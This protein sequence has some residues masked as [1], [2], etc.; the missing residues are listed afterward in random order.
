MTIR[1]GYHYGL[2]PYAGPPPSVTGE[3]TASSFGLFGGAEFD[4]ARDRM[5]FYLWRTISDQ[6]E[7][8]AGGFDA[9]GVGLGG[10]TLDAHHLYDPRTHALFMGD[11]RHVAS[12]P[13]I[14]TYAGTGQPPAFPGQ[15][16]G[17]PATAARLGYANDVEVAPDGS[18]F[19]AEIVSRDS[20]II[21]RIRPDGTAETYVSG[22]GSPRGIALGPDGSLYVTQTNLGTILRIAPDRTITRFAGTG[23]PSGPRGDGGPATSALVPLPIEVA[24]APDGSVYLTDGNAV[25]RVGPDGIITTAVGGNFGASLGDGGP[26]RDAQL[27]FIDGLAVG[28]AGELYIGHSDNGSGA[29]NRIRR[30]DTGGT[31]TT[32]AGEGPDPDIRGDGGP[33]TEAT[34]G[35][36]FGMDVG[37]DGA[38]YFAERVGGGGH[39]RRLGA[40]GVITT[41]AGRTA[42]TFGDNA[43]GDRGPALRALLPSVIGVAVAPDGSVYVGHHGS[44]NFTGYVRRITRPLPIGEGGAGFIPSPD[45]AQAFAFD[46]DGRHVRTVD[47][48]TGGT[49]LSF[50][51]DSAGR[52][53]TITDGDGNVTT[54][55]RAGASVAI[56]APG[57][58]RTELTID[59]EGW[60]SSFEPPDGATQTAAY[61]ANGLMES[62]TD[63]RGGE[64][65][66][67]FNA[68]GLL[69]RDED[70]AGGVTHLSR[71][72]D[73]GRLPR[74]PHH[75]AR[76]HPGLRGP[77]P[78]RRRHRPAVHRH[79]GRR[80][81]GRVTARRHAERDAIPTAWRPTPRAARTR[82]GTSTSPRPPR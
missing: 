39:I 34:I 69:T 56:V 36:P 28:S 19:V 9:R 10:W 4:G 5:D 55:E 30:V 20:G 67:E 61:Q 44:E 78:A 2:V 57:G 21:R 40:D 23:S 16:D 24:A 45:G 47:G 81:G 77:Q 33:G 22:I 29:G 60:L 65:R 18:V 58:Q 35:G 76:P 82:S 11:G 79:G 54:V 66:F 53:A 41:F 62:F 49:L 46:A 13:I 32:V 26:A 38:L 71:S 72:G 12:E 8:T 63:A 48:T 51:Y 37:P 68:S 75:G 43:L 52:L 1:L 59:A 6:A 73:R 31:I 15:G 17:G 3:T 74:H 70:A 80:H 14:T 25:R 50:T 64:H 42:D 27:G 7:A